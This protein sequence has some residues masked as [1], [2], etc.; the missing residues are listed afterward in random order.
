MLECPDPTKA[1]I[2]RADKHSSKMNNKNDL[3]T[4]MPSANVS[5]CKTLNGYPKK[6]TSLW[7][8]LFAITD[9]E[10]A[11]VSQIRKTA[12]K[13]ERTGLKSKLPA[14]TPHGTMKINKPKTQANTTPNGYIVIDI[15]ADDN[16]QYDVWQMFDI[17]SGDPYTML[18]SRSC[19]G[20]G[21][22]AVWR[23][24]FVEGQRDFKA[25]FDAINQYLQREYNITI[26]KKCSNI[27]AKRYITLREERLYINTNSEQWTE[28]K[29]Q[30]A[31]KAKNES[32]RI[33]VVLPLS[34]EVNAI[35]HSAETIADFL[36]RLL[37]P[38]PKLKT[39]PMYT[40][41]EGCLYELANGEQQLS[42]RYDYTK[43]LILNIKRED[44]SI[45]KRRM[46]GSR[47]VI[48]WKNGERRTKK[49]FKDG[50]ILK[51]LNDGITF[52][53][54]FVFLANELLRYFDLSDGRFT[55]EHF[56]N[57]VLNAWNAD[58]RLHHGSAPK[59]KI[60]KAEMAK[61]NMTM[62]QARRQAQRELCLKL[63]DPL[64]CLDLS[65][66]VQASADAA[67]VCYNTMARRMKEEGI[68]T[69]KQQVK[70]DMEAYFATGHNAEGMTEY[71]DCTLTQAKDYI[72]K[73][74]DAI[75]DMPSTNKATRHKQMLAICRMLSICNA[76]TDQMTVVVNSL[77]NLLKKKNL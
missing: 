53:D 5:W 29:V 55:K 73:K 36:D 59:W 75:W 65:A 64:S 31:N 28:K 76:S 9:E 3:K 13:A 17:M 39:E 68:R 38:C 35:W 8:G 25:Y 74:E 16:K 45:D 6:Q 20:R 18:C 50:I 77:C 37:T 12:S 7:D 54:Y 40:H 66:S 2:I 60:N 10:K 57:N 63:N 14:V 24:G 26:D 72:R 47:T 43:A 69:D 61:R 41:T 21:V 44:G 34:E 1:A 33:D 71:C 4:I 11:L 49:L 52:D 30:Q 70:D 56:A 51:S 32:E 23:L 19:S 22:L 46:S 42:R 62:P 67:N 58:N 48:K 27:A 15:D